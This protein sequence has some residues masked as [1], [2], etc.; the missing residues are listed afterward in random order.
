MNIWKTRSTK[1]IDKNPWWHYKMD[2]FEIPGVTTGKYYYCETPGSACVIPIDSEG[3]ILCVKQYRYLAERTSIEFPGGG[4]KAD[5]TIEDAVRAEL[6]EEAGVAADQL[7][8]IATIYPFPGL[9]KEA[10]YIYLATGLREV[11]GAHQDETEEFELLRATPNDIEQFIATG[12]M[13]DG[14]ALGAWAV[15][16]PHVLRFI[17]ENQSSK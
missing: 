16:R 15:V 13:T 1:V 17:D 5:Q 2:E 4:I 12:E 14:W 8:F 3:K 6:A 11:S 7:Q 9:V 10:Q